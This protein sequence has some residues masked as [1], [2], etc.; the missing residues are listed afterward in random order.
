MAKDVP[1]ERI[2]FLSISDGKN[3]TE[4]Q[5]LHLYVKAVI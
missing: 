3:W 4:T 5:F 1:N 2:Y